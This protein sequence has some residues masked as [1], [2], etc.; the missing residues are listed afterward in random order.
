MS[1]QFGWRREE[2]PLQQVEPMAGSWRREG[3]V[4]VVAVAGA[5]L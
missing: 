3:V 2:Q 4:V 1:G 5:A